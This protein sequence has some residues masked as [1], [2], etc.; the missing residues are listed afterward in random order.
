M[1]VKDERGKISL[2]IQIMFPHGHLTSLSCNLHAEPPCQVDGRVQEGGVGLLP[3]WHT[4]ILFHR[5]DCHLLLLG[6]R[7]SDRLLLLHLQAVLSSGLIQL[8]L[9][10]NFK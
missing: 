7:H 10:I 2:K 5:H 1:E 4:D 9:K 6:D 8:I 3:V